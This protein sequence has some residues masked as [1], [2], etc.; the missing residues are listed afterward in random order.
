MATRLPATDVVIIGAGWSGLTAAYELA[1][2]GQRCVVIERGQFRHDSSSFAAPE[3]HDELEYGLRH[4]HMI[5]PAQQTVTF[6]HTPQDLALPM[7][8]LGS[9]LPGMGLGGAGIH[10]NGQQWRALA[11]DMNLRSHFAERYGQ[12]FLDGIPDLTIQDYPMSYED[13]RP[14]YD[15]FESIT[16]CSGQVGNLDGEIIAG[17]N[18]FEAPRG[19]YPNP[20]LKQPL[21]TSM[22][23]ETAAEMGYH[24]FPF[25]SA[26][27]SQRYVNPYGAELM[28]CTYCGF[29]E[30]FGCGYYAKADP[31][32][33]VYDRIR[34]HRNFELRLGSW[35]QRIEKSEDGHAT[36]VTYIDSD[37]EEVF[38][39]ADLVLVC[40][41]SLWNV[42]LLLHSGLGTPYDP[43]AR[44][45]TVG[46]NYAYQTIS[47]VNVLYDRE[48]NTNPF[49]GAGALGMVIDDF[50]TDN[51]DHTGL[52]FVG[53]GYFAATQYHGRPI[54]YDP[55]PDGVRQWGAEYKKAKR[56]YYGS[57]VRLLAHMSSASTSNN[58]LDLDPTYTDTFGR[59]LLRM[60]FDFPENDRRMS[61][62][63]TAQLKEIADRMGGDHVTV[64][65]RAA[66]PYTIVP[67]QTT[68]NVGGTVIGDDPTTSVV[69]PYGQM[70]DH[71]NVF[72][73]GASLFPQ[74]FGYNPTNHLMALAYWEL[75]AIK[76]RYLPNPAPLVSRS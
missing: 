13:L 27:V 56:Q 8:R 42:H 41:Y 15:F 25:P 62:H 26:N 64:S 75:D 23:A 35:V 9:F 44:T 3:E 55:T 12:A 11:A 58:Y 20:P 50:N 68:H 65:A 40:A 10:W 37:G 16:G 39:P 48:L 60:T 36:G 76:S 34:D 53:G 71:P 38:Q 21:A 67:Y 30:Q 43:A 61:Q 52:G 54:E 31:I 66:E 4:N 49:M 7:R 28:P 24:P 45:G 74:N 29:C 59:P 22:F 14:Y 32:I 33:C 63:L 18:P 5:N 69:N 1:H 72:V 2:N 51:F 46:R 17:G 6:R 70:W 57:T 19:E 73:F 47:A